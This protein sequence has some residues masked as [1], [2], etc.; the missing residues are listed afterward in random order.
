MVSEPMSWV[1]FPT[2][3][4]FSSAV[5]NNFHLPCCFL[6]RTWSECATATRTQAGGGGG[7]DV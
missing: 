3:H 4:A 5:H 6:V 1:Q 7:G 2:G